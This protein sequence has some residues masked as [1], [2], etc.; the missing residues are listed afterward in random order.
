MDIKFVGFKPNGAQFEI[1]LSDSTT[2]VIGRGTDCDITVPIS[3]VSRKH[4]EINVNG[5]HVRIR[6]L[7]SANGTYVNNNR[8]SEVRLSAGDRVVLGPLVLTLQVDGDPAQVAPAKVVEQAPAAAAELD[9][10][11]LALPEDALSEEAPLELDEAA[12]SLDEGPISLDESPSAAGAEVGDDAFADL[13]AGSD[14]AESAANVLGESAVD[15][16]IDP[17]SALEMLAGEEPTSEDEDQE[18]A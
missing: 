2:V 4:C 16:E 12:I 9:V 18:Q 3:S 10:E 14:E 11:G 1:P 5:S 8:I 13:L 15:D 7:G 6:D 17:I